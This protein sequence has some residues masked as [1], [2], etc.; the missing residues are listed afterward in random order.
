MPEL[1]DFFGENDNQGNMYWLNQFQMKYL[2]KVNAIRADNYILHDQKLLQQFDFVDPEKPIV[3]CPEPLTFINSLAKFESGEEK[4]SVFKDE[5][6]PTFKEVSFSGGNQFGNGAW[7]NKTTRGINLR[8]GSLEGAISDAEL[9]PVTLGDDAVHALVAGVTG[10]GKSVLLDDMILNL[11][12]EYPAW[13]LDLYL[14]DFKKVE[15]TPFLSSEERVTPHVKA[16]GATEELRYIVS[17]LEH[18]KECMIAR[19]NLF[20]YVGVNAIDKF[21]DAYQIVL[22]RTLLIIDEFQQMFLDATPHQMDTIKSVLTALTKKGRAT[23]IHLLFASQDLSGTLGSSVLSNFKARFALHLSSDLSSSMIGSNEASA[24]EKG[25]VIVNLGDKQSNRLYRVPNV[26]TELDEVKA[27]MLDDRAK[28]NLNYIL[29]EVVGYGKQTNFEKVNKFYQ[30]EVTSPIELIRQLKQNLQVRSEVAAILSANPEYV[31]NFILGPAVRYAEERVDVENIFIESGVRKSIACIS[32]TVGACAYLLNLFFDNFYYSGNTYEHKVLVKDNAV[33]SVFDVTKTFN[34]RRESE[35]DPERLKAPLIMDEKIQ[36]FLENFRNTK[37]LYDA[38]E[39]YQNPAKFCLFYLEEKIV[40]I[41]RTKKVNSGDP[42]IDFVKEEIEAIKQHFT[43]EMK[44]TQVIS[45]E[46]YKRLLAYPTEMTDNKMHVLK[47]LAKMPDYLNMHK[48]HHLD[49][50]HMSVYLPKQIWWII[51]VENF[52]VKDT[53]WSEIAKEGPKYNILP[54]FFTRDDKELKKVYKDCCH[55]IFLDVRTQAIYDRYNVSYSK[56]GLESLTIDS[57]F[58]HLNDGK[59][60]KR[61]AT[62]L[63]DFAPKTI[64]FDKLIIKT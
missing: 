52:Q 27:A 54:I 34:A 50:R 13:E 9:S 22:P 43:A 41:L 19:E 29:D 16:V 30:E 6:I 14:L 31:D 62:D 3:V 44:R 64:N 58:T 24:L 57:H 48:Q 38:I 10:S 33:T 32:D 20:K 35:G 36:A 55:Y 56:K 7:F 28:S 11:L 1:D 25:Q 60:F 18:L 26:N 42:L 21:R 61:F 17:L 63:P 23:G 59:S 47:A 51:G 15:F 46:S 5:L 53:I 45:E 39:N 12:V 37:M 49:N 40:K 2:S 8:P 4:K